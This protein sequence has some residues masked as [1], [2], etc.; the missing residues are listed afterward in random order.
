MPGYPADRRRRLRRVTPVLIDVLE[1]RTLLSA[2]SPAPRK[3]DALVE[4]AH[5]IGSP[6]PATAVTATSA[7]N[8]SLNVPLKLVE[9][10]GGTRIAVKVSVA[11][12][13]FRQ[14]LLDTGSVGMYIANDR[15]NRTAYVTTTQSFAQH[16]SSGI[17]YSG[18]VILT[19]LSFAPG[20]SASNVFIGLVTKAKGKK[21]ADWNKQIKNNR[22]PYEKQFYGTLGLSLEPGNSKQ[23]GSL[24]N[25]IAQ[26]PGNLNTGFIIH[27]GGINGQSPML[28]IG[29]TPENTKGFVT[30]PI[31]TAAGLGS[32][33]SYG[34]G[35]ANK[36]LAWD[37][38][39]GLVQ[40]QING[41][42]AFTAPT[43]FDTG[44]PATTLYT[45]GVPSRLKSG[46][47]LSNGLDFEA[48]LA[49]GLAWAF[50][51]GSQVNVNQVDVGPSRSSG[52]VNSGIGLFFSYDVMFDIKDGLIGFRPTSSA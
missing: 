10:G 22:P 47:D 5:G 1:A 19:S 4:T 24:Y 42:P 40:Y 25:V 37:D 28:T 12:G 51:T 14:Y 2:M 50:Q 11:G 39:G 36:V 46:A 16:Y 31:P 23:Q 52:T 3:L 9:A 45:G 17:H 13:P 33:Y 20:Q 8:S 32:T 15:L 27:T 38:K 43:V 49:Q 21:V 48:K 29:L 34:N 41:L 18:P 26:L 7:A 44:E 35:A 6:K 30:I